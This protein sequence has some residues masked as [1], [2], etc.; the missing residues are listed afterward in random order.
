MREFRRLG[1]VQRVED[2]GEDALRPDHLHLALSLGAV[3]R[4]ARTC[5]GLLR[6]EPPRLEDHLRRRGIFRRCADQVDDRQDERHREAAEHDPFAAPGHVEKVAGDAE[7][8]ILPRRS[9]TRLRAEEVRGRERV[10]GW[11]G[12]GLGHGVHSSAARSGWRMPRARSQ[13]ARR[14]PRN[15]PRR[16]MKGSGA[17]ARTRLLSR[18]R[19]R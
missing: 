10:G 13:N 18:L 19:N 17:N 2:R 12:T 14:L 4:R 15:R 1:E 3:E 7:R 6:R 11:G 16:S 8:R 5:H 9:V